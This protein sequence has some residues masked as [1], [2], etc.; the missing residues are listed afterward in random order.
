MQGRHFDLSG[1]PLTEG[2]KAWTELDRL[3]WKMFNKQTGRNQCCLCGKKKE[4]V[5]KLIAGLHGAVCSDCI[6]LCNDIL[7]HN[8]KVKPQPAETGSDSTHPQ[9]VAPGVWDKIDHIDEEILRLS[10]GRMR[11]TRALRE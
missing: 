1:S 9:G 7:N 4:Q 8:S 5:T 6:D 10:S 11:L 2:S 3:G